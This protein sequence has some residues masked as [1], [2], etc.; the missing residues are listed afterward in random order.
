M[1]L[2]LIKAPAATPSAKL[3]DWGAVGEPVGRPA[4]KLRGL[5]AHEGPDVGV[6]EC[7]PGKFR[8]QIRHAEFC[9]FI[10]G[11]CVFHADAGERLD[12]RTGDAVLFPPN[13]QGTWEILETTRKTYIILDA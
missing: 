2:T 13:T 5:G 1:R 9:H 10:A 12:I 7:S 3:E 4:P 8:R 11:H 6:W